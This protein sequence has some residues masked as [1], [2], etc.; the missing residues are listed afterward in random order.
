M[1][2]QKILLKNLKGNITDQVPMWFMR[3]AGRHLPEYNQIRQNFSNF[4]EFCYSPKEA[5]E[6]TLQPIRR[7]GMDGAILFSDILVIPDALGQ[8]VAFEKGFGPKLGELN[9]SDLKIENV[10]SFL[11]PIMETIDLVET[12]LDPSVTFLGFCGSPW[13]VATYMVQGKGMRDSEAARRYAY[14]EKE[15]FLKLLDILVESSLIYLSNQVKAGVDAV[16]IFDSW[17]GVLDE[18]AFDEFCIK[19]T[20][21]LVKEFKKLHPHTPVIGFPRGAGLR[22]KSF[23]DQ[24]PVDA[25]S[26]DQQVSLSWAR[27][28]LQSKVCLQGNLDNMRLIAGGEDLIQAADH[29]LKEW[30]KGPMVFNLN[31]GVTPDTPIEHVEKIVEYV[32]SYKR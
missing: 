22:A 10:E 31:H 29:I 8:S 1:E 14:K 11:S 23:I 3:Q 18:Q 17:S 19:P 7:Y 9:L 2:N 25:I 30:S 6:V 27:E 15:E 16:Q 21:K 5:A 24:V 13:T 28:N 12:Q 32:H 4:L 20:E 26:L